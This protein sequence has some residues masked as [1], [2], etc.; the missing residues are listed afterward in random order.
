M[1]ANQS[2]PQNGFV[3]SARSRERL[4]GVHKDLAHIVHRAL[5]LSAI[6]FTVLEGRRSI[7]RQTLLYENG[8]TRT[9]NSRHLSGHAV[10]L[11]AWVGGG[12]RWDWPLYET[13]NQA[14]Q[15]AAAEFCLPVEWGGDWQSFRDGPHFQ[16]PWSDYPI[17]RQDQDKGAQDE[18][19]N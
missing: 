15:L 14:M 4:A 1:T 2:N 13:I 8:A 7:E 12:I 11:G 18:E 10:D 5:Q 17:L 6:D 9:L 16:L 3:L 19:G